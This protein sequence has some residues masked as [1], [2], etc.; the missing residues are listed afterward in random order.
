MTR[1]RIA[2]GTALLALALAVLPARAA[3]WTRYENCRL[4]SGRYADGDS[5]HVA[6]PA[7]ERIFRLY[8]VDAP[9][10]DTNFPE[11][12]K[13]QAEYFEVSTR[14]ALEIGEAARDFTARFL[15]GG[16]TVFARGEDAEGRSELPREFALIRVG[17][18]WLDVALVEAGLARVYG[19]SAPLP[20]G[21]AAKRHWSDLRAAEQRAKATRAGAWGAAAVGAAQGPRDRKPSPAPRGRRR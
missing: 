21:T 13:E 19:K 6:T 2:S 15:R 12:V 11:R 20:D 4:V 5:F 17:D 1:R 8:Y 7:G 16:F 14:R 18:R 3:D 10:T 9:E